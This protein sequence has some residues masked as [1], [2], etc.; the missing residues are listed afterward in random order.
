MTT[1]DPSYQGDQ[2][3][4]KRI[5]LDPETMTP[6]TV[7][8]E[9]DSVAGPTA[10]WPDGATS[11]I[12]AFKGGLPS[13]TIADE[14]ETA[15]AALEAL[16]SGQEIDKELLQ[17]YLRGVRRLEMRLTAIKE[18]LLLYARETGP[19]GKARLTFRELGEELSQHYSTVAERHQRIVDG[20][21]ADWRHWVTQ[22]TE[23]ATFYTNGGE[24]PQPP[25][26]QRAHETGVFDSEEPGKVKARCRCGWSGPAGTSTV[27]AS[28]QGKDHELNP[29]GV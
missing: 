6:A 8:M 29:L 22:H 12:L 5:S 28:R 18:E 3:E 17:A 26:S 9:P 20:D 11:Y 13:W 14:A 23:R 2:W 1:Y 7:V 19:D 25:Q 15:I 21:S 4:T 24:P 27:T 16:Q 10:Y